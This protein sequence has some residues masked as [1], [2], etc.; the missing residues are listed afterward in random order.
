LQA[1]N[2]NDKQLRTVVGNLRRA[3]SPNS[4]SRVSDAQL[5]ERFLGHCDELAFEMLVWRHG[6]MVLNVCRRVLRDANDAEDAFQATFLIFVRKLGSIGKREAV[7]SWLYKVAYRVALRARQRA[8]LR[9]TETLADW[10]QLPGHRAFDDPAQRAL[11]KDLRPVLDEEVNRLPEK[12]RTPFV[13][14]YLEGMAYPEVAE[15]LG[16]P[17]GTVSSRLTT[18]KELLRKRLARRGVVLSAALLGGV[19]AKAATAAVTIGLANS[20]MQTVRLIAGGPAAGA[21]AVSARAVTLAEGVLKAMLMTKVKIVTVALLAAGVLG[22]GTSL[23]IQRAA[24]AGAP[25]TVEKPSL[26]PPLEAPE[27]TVADALQPGQ[28][29]M[30]GITL[31]TPPAAEAPNPARNSNP[32]GVTVAPPSPATAPVATANRNLP[33]PAQTTG[34]APPPDN[35]SALAARLAKVEAR[36]T[37]IEAQLANMQGQSVRPKTENPYA[38]V[39]PRTET[40]PAPKGGEPDPRKPGNDS[41]GKSKTVLLDGFD[42]FETAPQEPIPTINTLSF[43]LPVDVGKELVPAIAQLELYI[44]GDRGKS[45]KKA[46]AIKDKLEAFPVTVPHDGVYWFKVHAIYKLGPTSPPEFD[47]KTSPDLKMRVVTKPPK[48]HDK[49]ATLAD[50]EAQLKAIQKRIA[51]L[52]ALKGEK[53]GN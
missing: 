44:S 35:E 36:L 19:L 47:Q 38:P 7:G 26:K 4:T 33:Q 43:K 46:V 52:Q 27:P 40:T 25:P 5:L 28:K 39:S 45:W 9:R 14:F 6:S 21:G 17:K 11:W 18:A 12:Y 51:E 8:A 16:C 3:I 31:G 29:P 23:A 2:M 10:E 34:T 20:T 50:L 13:L 37:L 15:E 49:D 53:P 48:D 42:A 1:A 30:G 24:Q 22:F 41:V 32:F